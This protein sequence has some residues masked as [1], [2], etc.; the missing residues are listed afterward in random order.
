M[1]AIDPAI[2]RRIEDTL[3][4]IESTEG[5]RVLFACESG[6]R[7][8][9]FAS[10]DS[11]YDARFLYLRPRDWY[12]SIDLERQRDVIELPIED[13]L[14]VNGWDLRKALQLYRKSNPV[15]HEWLGSPIVY[16]DASPAVARLRAL[17]D[18]Y[19]SPKRCWHH[20]GSMARGNYRSYLKRE[21]VPGKKYLYVL[22]PL[23][24]VRW[25]LNGWGVVPTLFPE[26]IE[27]VVDDPQLKAEIDKLLEA[28]RA[29]RE[30]DGIPRNPVLDAYIESQIAELE[31]SSGELEVP[32]APL[33]PLDRLFLDALDESW[34]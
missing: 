32:S 13:E 27:R 16:R 1:E 6:S 15:I 9:G 3:A 5:V 19:Y 2:R 10:S 20:Y 25:I 8:W 18:E 21:E 26:L 30:L 4:E 33:E 24:A 17:A 31:A 12:L 11:D 34:G 14:D 23:L 29:G 28:K 7:A 22:R